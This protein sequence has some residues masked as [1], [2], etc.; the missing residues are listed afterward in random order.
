[1][2]RAISTCG[3]GN[4]GVPFTR[5]TFRNIFRLHNSTFHQQSAEGSL[6]LVK[7]SS[8]ATELNAPPNAL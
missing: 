5:K 1:M 4:A 8:N 6:P 2:F 7:A 3:I